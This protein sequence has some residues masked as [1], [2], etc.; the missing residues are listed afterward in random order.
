[1]PERLTVTQKRDI[2]RLVQSRIAEFQS[3]WSDPTARDLITRNLSWSFPR[4]THFHDC[5]ALLG[6]VLKVSENRFWESERTVRYLSNQAYIHQYDQNWEVLQEFLEKVDNYDDYRV[7]ALERMSN[8]D[9]YGNLEP[10]IYRLIRVLKPTADE[11]R[12]G[13]KKKSQRRRGY[14]DKGT[15][16]PNWQKRNVALLND[17][18][19][20]RRKLV[21]HPLL[22]RTY[23][24]IGEGNPPEGRSGLQTPTGKKGGD[25]S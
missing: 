6:A 3:R 16:R 14:R 25:S 13:R 11:E 9:F 20:D 10:K 8:E 1:M 19:E 7:Y 15:L 22:G 21:K 5:L 17:D 24:E 12:R 4:V 23:E 18:R 2:E